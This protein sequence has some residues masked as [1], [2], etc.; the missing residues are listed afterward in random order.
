MA[1]QERDNTRQRQAEGIATAKKIGKKFGRPVAVLPAAIPSIYTD[2]RAG[3]RTAV[4]A[5]TDL[6][7]KK[8]TFYKL[9]NQYEKQ[10]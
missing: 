5:F 3:N 7:L 1:Q 6:G 9:V 10:R 4:S 2:W 8:T